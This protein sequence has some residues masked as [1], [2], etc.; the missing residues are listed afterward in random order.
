MPMTRHLASAL[1][2]LLPV[3]AAA[4][5]GGD[6]PADFVLRHARIY[7]ADA[8]R[9]VAQSLAVRGGRIVFVGSDAD[10]AAFV[11]P[12][13]RVEDAAGRL[14]IPGLIDAH[15]HP[16]GIVELDVCDLKSAAKSLAQMTAFVRG[17]I[18]RYKVPAGQWVNVRQWNFSNGNEPDAQHPTL[19][20]ALDLASVHHPIQLIGND[21]HHGAFNSLALASARTAGG[22]VIGYS[23]ESLANEFQAMRKLVGVDASGEPNGTANEESRDVLAAADLL[24]VDFK[25]VMAAPQRVPQRLNSVGITGVLDAVVTPEAVALY[26][27]LA[28][29]G[30]LTVRATLAQ[31]Y[32]PDRIRTPA[33]E[34]D[35]DRMVAAASAIRARF[36]NHPLIRADVVK[37]FAD[38]VLEGNPFANP[39]TLPESAGLKPYL[40]PIFAKGAD[41]RLG[42]SGYVDTDGVV[43]TEVRA[44]PASFDAAAAVAEFQKAH[45][46]HPGQCALSSGQLQHERAVIME[47][48]KRFHAAGFDLH[49]HAI[50]D[51]AVRTA[52]DAI[53]AARAANGIST[54]HDALAHVQLVHPD[55]VARIG[56]DKLYLAMTYAWCYTNPQYDLSVVPFYDKV[57]GGDAA[58]LHPANGYYEKNAYPVRSMRDAGAVLM[59]G[60]DAPVDTRDPRPFVN[61]SMAV[62]RAF[63]GMRALNP[64]ESVELRDVL[65]AY[66][67]NGARYL[68][69]GAEAGSL[70]VGKSADFVLLDRDILALADGGKAG[71]IART[72][73]LKTWFMGRPVYTRPKKS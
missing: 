30:Q 48:A 55:D 18:E 8:G 43:C 33:G 73:V 21:G 7:T 62:T 17:C 29:R 59:G 3:V 10:A 25:E 71:D 46:Y 22:K 60:S 66:T 16:S 14:V 32:D 40:Q 63:P 31:F 41:G 54:Q 56:R 35:F 44:H 34:P 9:S 47:F 11:G 27:T 39:P 13:T 64:A 24:N 1:L 4:T 68:H 57:S 51:A 5:P 20:K 42:V 50:S 23:K 36:A 12:K 49:I 72:R 65:D 28:S 69:L 70:E 37:L 58:A 52:V 2:A 26:D 15:I 38:G 45:G 53:E 61:M 6:A 67:I 19:R